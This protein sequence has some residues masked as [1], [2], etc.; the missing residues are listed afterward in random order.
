MGAVRA[1]SDRGESAQEDSE[2][3]DAPPLPSMDREFSPASTAAMSGVTSFATQELAEMRPDVMIDALLDLDEATNKILTFVSALSQDE[4]SS[5]LAE[6]E[7]PEARVTAKLI[8][9]REN[10]RL[11]KQPF[12]REP[13]INLSIVLRGILG[14]PHD[15]GVGSGAWR[16]DNIFYKANMAILIYSLLS[17]DEKFMGSM[18]EKLDLDFPVP[19]FSSLGQIGKPGESRLLSETLDLAIDLRTQFCIHLLQN[20]FG[21]QNFD[22]DIVVRDVFYEN[23]GTDPVILKGWSLNTLT[24]NDKEKREVYRRMQ[25]LRESFGADTQTVDI[26]RLKARFPWSRFISKVI[27]WCKLRLN[28]IE[29][30]LQSSGGLQVIQSM[31]R[32]EYHR[33]QTAAQNHPASDHQE[34]EG[35]PVDILSHLPLNMNNAAP[36]ASPSI[37]NPTPSQIQHFKK[38]IKKRKRESLGI[39]GPKS[40]HSARVQSMQEVPKPNVASTGVNVPPIGPSTRNMGSTDSPVDPTNPA[41]SAQ[42]SNDMVTFDNGFDDELFLADDTEDAKS[43]RN[44]ISTEG[45]DMISQAV[46]KA[47]KIEFQHNKENIPQDLEPKSRHAL[48]DWQPNATRVAWSSQEST[49]A[50]PSIPKKSTRA[51]GKQKAAPTFTADSGDDEDDAF[52]VGNR[53]TPRRP[54]NQPGPVRRRAPTPANRRQRSTPVRIE[55]LQERNQPFSSRRQAQN[56]NRDP[57]GSVSPLGRR[58]QN[59]DSTRGDPTAL[60]QSQAETYLVVNQQSKV[61]TAK[62]P[63]PAQVRRPWTVAEIECLI[64]GVQ[65]YGTGWAAIK[66]LDDSGPKILVHRNQVGLK[67]KARNMKFDYLK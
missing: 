31:V 13:Y 2:L 47:R 30:S 20:Q 4:V 22:P 24:M 59:A 60:P 65:K 45:N 54:S 23:L 12:G 5:F 67:D 7:D 52:S 25:L 51:Q 58:L 16:P 27:S 66:K 10:L 46:A 35:N 29:D 18:L 49:H 19:F 55:P 15:Q 63:R 34:N 14:V 21:H 39:E 44:V 17:S 28:E 6:L 61:R 43:S 9:Y 8:R 3:D 40:K 62:G 48:I 33:K 26:D 36:P 1:G 64:D 37:K 57:F 38:T 41:I 32:N 42:R 50:G 53:P 11:Q 56:N